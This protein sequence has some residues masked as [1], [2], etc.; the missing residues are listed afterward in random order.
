[1][2]FSQ[3]RGIA[4][5]GEHGGS[6]EHTVRSHQASWIDRVLLYD[7]NFNYHAEHH[8]RPQIPSCH[9][10]ALQRAI[11]ANEVSKS[12]FG[13]LRDIYKERKSSDG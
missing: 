3:L 11:G 7:V 10:P 13:T 9:L 12:M 1:L 5:H 8:A 2:F 4:E 6:G